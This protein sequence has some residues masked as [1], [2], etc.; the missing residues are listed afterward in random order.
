MKINK[1]YISNGDKIL[2]TIIL[3]FTFLP[4]NV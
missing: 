3:D 1:Y 4:Y 2:E